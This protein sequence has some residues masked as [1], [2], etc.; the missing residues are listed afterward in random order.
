M[1]ISEIAE[2]MLDQKNVS[3]ITL[4]DFLNFLLKN[5]DYIPMVK[6]VKAQKVSGVIYVPKKHRGKRVLVIIEN[7]S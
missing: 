7:G 2:E 6:E 3:E 5:K 1:T 4:S